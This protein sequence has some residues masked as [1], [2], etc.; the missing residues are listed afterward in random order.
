MVLA[1]D[2]DDAAPILT[3]TGVPDSVRPSL[4]RELALRAAV[5]G[6]TLTGGPPGPVQVRLPLAAVPAGRQDD[7][8]GER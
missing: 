7:E 2:A 8:E 1:L 3:A 6:G 5:I 4:C